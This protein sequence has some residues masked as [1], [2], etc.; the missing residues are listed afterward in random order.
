MS[1]RRVK[2]P[3]DGSLLSLRGVHLGREMVDKSEEASFY[4]SLSALSKNEQIGTPEVGR[5]GN[6]VRNQPINF[7]NADDALST[8]V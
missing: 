3:L 8:D 1:S 5:S 4:R 6:L 2:S 7:E